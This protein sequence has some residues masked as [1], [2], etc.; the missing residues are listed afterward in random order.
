MNASIIRL[1]C[2]SS[3]ISGVQS[4]SASKRSLVKII[5]MLATSNSDRRAV[6]RKFAKSAFEALP[7]PSA[8]LLV[9][10]RV[11]AR[12]CSA[13]RYF[14]EASSCSERENSL[15]VTA[16]ARCQISRSSKR[17]CFSFNPFNRALLL[18]APCSSLPA[19]RLARRH[20]AALGRLPRGQQ[21]L[22]R[23]S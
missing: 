6:L 20:A 19:A 22:K 7:E 1:C 8:I 12:S 23:H 3:L 2:S 21:D 17:N 15:P 16:A 11:A 9:M 5:S 4:V 10:L 18:Q 14:R 13:K